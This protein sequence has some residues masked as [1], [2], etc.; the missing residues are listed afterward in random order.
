MAAPTDDGK[1]KEA[2]DGKAFYGYLYE[3]QKPFPTPKPLLDALL[4]AV[5]LH[6][7]DSIGD[8][9]DKNLTPHKLAA[10]YKLAGH[11]YDGLFV[12]MP[13]QSISFIY[14]V[15]GCQHI[16]VQPGSDTEAPTIPALTTKGFVRWQS[17]QILLEPQTHVPIMQYAVKNW[18]LKNPNDGTPFPTDLPR[19]AFPLETDADTDLW[20]QEL[21]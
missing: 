21:L 16:L 10:F 12:E 18:A 1:K 8:K 15:Q 3:K 11:N 9:N 20:H 17:I 19:E 7:I 6:I 13:P 14:Q 2:K 4:R 5:A